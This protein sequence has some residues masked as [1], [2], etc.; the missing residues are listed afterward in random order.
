M[1][2]SRYAFALIMLALPLPALAASVSITNL[3]PGTTVTAASLVSL[4][5]VPSGISYPTYRLQDSF[6]GSSASTN[7]IEPGGRFSWVPAASDAGTHVLTFTVAG[8]DTSASI[9]QTITVL[10]PPSLTIS[11]PSPGSV[12]LPGTPLSFQVTTNGFSNPRFMIGDKASYSS[13]TASN[14]DS[15][16]RFTWT[17]V[18]SDN[19]DH[20]ITVYV[21]DDAGHN[22]SRSVSVRVGAGA[23][24]AVMLLSP[25]ASV[26]PGQLLTFTATPNGY[27]PTGFSVLDS[28]PNSTV[29]NASINLSGQFSWVPSQSD[30]GTH[31]LT[32]TG[33]VGAFGDKASA[34]QTITVTGPGGTASTASATQGATS[35]D[36][37]L[38]GLQAKLAA[39]TGALATARAGASTPAAVTFTT[40]L[41]PGSSGDEV[42]ALQEVLVRLG[43]LAATPNGNYGPATTAAVQAFQK[44]HGLE[45]LGVVGPATRAALNAGADAGTPAAPT[46]AA[47]TGQRFVFEHFMGLG[48]DDSAQ[49]TELQKRLTELGHYTGAVT[50]YFGPATEAAVKKFQKVS[51][52]PE[53][54]YVASITRAALNR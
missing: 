20:E 10:P 48:D 4:M 22:A 5:L 23:G 21:S 17:P 1:N 7:N 24:L 35:T 32:I 49:V 6:S 45:P 27:S 44:A 18:I 26:S 34:T 41:K 16:G 42:R 39:L 37:T 2:L 52:I 13:I 43:H 19:G 30:I 8:S 12:V 51:G 40:Y 36:T 54:G 38:A 50:G 29:T 9:S 15:S 46:Q 11:A 33:V 47:P 28:F 14:I 25:G 31:I 3:S 53:T